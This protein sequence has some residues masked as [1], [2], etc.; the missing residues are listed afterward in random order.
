MY[1]LLEACGRQYKVQEGEVV[2]FD[3]IEKSEGDK[4]TFESVM[5]LSSDGKLTIGDPYVAGVAVSGT[6]IGHGKDKKII[7]FKYKAKKN[8]RKKQGH[9]QPY[10][11]VLID[12]IN[13]VQTEEK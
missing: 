6:V 12:K 5:A 13:L 9:R 3:K 8:Y 7:V 11:K 1:A 10:T 2:F 4:V